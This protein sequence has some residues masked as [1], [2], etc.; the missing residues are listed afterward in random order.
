MK[1]CKILKNRIRD[2]KAFTLAEMLV[3]MLIMSFAGML[4]IG[5]LAVVTNAFQDLLLHSQT[6]MVLKEYMG[7]IRSGFLSADLD[8]ELVIDA[9]TSPD[10]RPAFTH[11]GL[12]RVGYYT[13]FDESGNELNNIAP[14]PGGLIDEDA[15]YGTIVF[16]PV[17]FDYDNNVA[18]KNSLNVDKQAYIPLVSNK[19]SD[20]FMAKIE[21]RF[22]ATTQMFIG[23]ITVKSARILSSGD[24]VELSGE[25]NVSPNCR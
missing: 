22:D 14:D 15:S 12:D 13:V 9:N 17:Y 7:E 18:V 24:H 5:G 6:Q 20:D 8:S 4:V 25:F 11:S 23:N 19:L 10:T 1:N 3:A 21:Y 16:Q 2:K